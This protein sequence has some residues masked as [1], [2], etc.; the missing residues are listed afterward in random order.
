M[1]VGVNI[2][3]FQNLCREKNKLPGFDYL[4]Y[5]VLIAKVG[6]Y[7]VWLIVIVEVC[8]ACVRLMFK[9]GGKEDI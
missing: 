5:G 4:A 3:E 8:T 2:T 9:L 6:L 7:S 1:V